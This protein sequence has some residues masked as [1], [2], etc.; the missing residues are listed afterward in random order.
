MILMTENTIYNALTTDIN[1]IQTRAFKAQKQVATGQR[2]MSAD[3]DPVAAARGSLLNASISSL[4]TMGRV[5]AIAQSHL[6]S[7]EAAITDAQSILSRARE[8]AI[9]GANGASSADDRAQVVA[10]TAVL[11]DGMLALANTQ[12]GGSYIFSGTSGAKPFADDGTYMGDSGVRALDVAP[13]VRINSNVPGS[14]VFNVVGGQNI[15][16]ILA[17][18]TSSLEGNDVQAV[19]DAIDQL[20]H[21]IDQLNGARS[22]VGGALSEISFSDAQRTDLNI[23]MR[24]DRSDTI[25]ID[26]AQ[27]MIRML[28]AQTAYQTAL[29]EATRILSQL[30]NNPLTR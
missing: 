8:L 17:R 13:G 3:D 12:V 21:S 30:Q 1:K 22:S 10:E 7:A 28:E 23:L 14:A 6:G 26:Q 11:K 27:A 5:A 15:I 2:V 24:K 20:D 9:L 16:G 4:D 25:E 19:Y 29:A 18:L